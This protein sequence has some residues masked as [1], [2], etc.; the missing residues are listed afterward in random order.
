MTAHNHRTHVPGCYRCELSRDEI[1]AARRDGDGDNDCWYCLGEGDCEAC[2]ER[3]ALQAEVERLRAE[4]AKLRAAATELNASELLITLP[5]GDGF[6]KT[7]RFVEAVKAAI[8]IEL[9]AI[10]RRLDGLDEETN[11]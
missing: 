6:A 2:T 7:E 3:R 4:N 1:E 11:R 8:A 9:D 10:T 5:A